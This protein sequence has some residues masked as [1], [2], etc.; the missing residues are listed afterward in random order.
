MARKK[1]VR[2]SSFLYQ[3][4]AVRFEFAIIAHERKVVEQGLRHEHSVEG[5]SMM[6]REFLEKR[7]LGRPKIQPLEAAFFDCREDVSVD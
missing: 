1:R 4:A 7:R 2:A 5:I 6:L 3:L